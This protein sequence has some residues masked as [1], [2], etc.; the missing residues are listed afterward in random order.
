MTPNVLSDADDDTSSRP[1][2]EGAES[3]T[4]SVAPEPSWR[5][6]LAMDRSDPLTLAFLKDR[7]DWE[8]A[9]K[10]ELTSALSFPAGLLTLLGGVV[11]VMV[12]DFSYGIPTLTYPFAVLIGL[13]TV[14][15]VACLVLFGLVFHRQ[16]YRYLPLLG[17]LEQ[18]RTEFEAYYVNDPEQPAEEFV[19]QVRRR[20]IDAADTNTR[21]NDEK[22]R[23]L[24]L[25]RA[26]LLVILVVTALAGVAF[27][28]D[29]FLVRRV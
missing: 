15:F 24:Y 29:Q 2:A 7:Y 16:R 25:G 13:D 6:D 17:D 1:D 8:L 21:R 14:A 12:R 3:C 23:F 26:M 18:S 22:S 5:E 28:V 19:A 9:R 10:A 4:T 27:V 20:I 11:A